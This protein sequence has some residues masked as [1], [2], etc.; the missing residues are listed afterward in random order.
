VTLSALL[1]ELPAK[2]RAV[3]V[4]RFYQDLSVPQI[5]EELGIPDGTVKSQLSRGLATMRTRLGEPEPQRT[6][7]S[8]KEVTS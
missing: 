1:R 4:L 7:S 6:D 5:A 8:D 2:Q 3:L